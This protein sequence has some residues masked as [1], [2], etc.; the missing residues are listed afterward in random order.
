MNNDIFGKT[1][2]IVRKH[3][4]IKLVATEIRRIY[5]VSQPNFHTR[6]FFTGNLLAIGFSIL[7]LSKILMYEFW[8]DYVKPQYGKRT[9]LC[10]MDTEKHTS[11]IKTLQAILKFDLILQFMK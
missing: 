5:L 6:N 4:D 3:R 9:K 2:E 1:M 10:Y 11:F 7:E 8:Y